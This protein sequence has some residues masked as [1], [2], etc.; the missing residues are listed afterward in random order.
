MKKSLVLI[1]VVMLSGCS[2][3]MAYNNL[4]RMIK[5]GV[6]D[7]VDLNSAQEDVLEQELERIHTWHR[8]NHLPQYAQ[9]MRTLAQQSVDEI[10]P[11]RM[12]EVSDQFE[13]WFDEM[14]EKFTPLIM[15]S[16]VR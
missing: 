1:V 16:L 13:F 9:L 10:S 6:S 2:I 15:G 3:K 14:E 11:A 7:Y 12:R 5:W 4:D 8:R